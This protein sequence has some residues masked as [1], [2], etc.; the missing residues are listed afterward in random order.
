MDVEDSDDTEIMQNDS[1]VLY[2]YAYVVW[3][4]AKP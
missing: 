4:R 3:S 2:L 1:A